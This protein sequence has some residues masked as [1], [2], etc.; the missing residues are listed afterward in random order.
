MAHFETPPL[1]SETLAHIGSFPVRNTMIMA[2]LAMAVLFLVAYFVRR[3]RYREVPGRFQGFIEIMVEALFN[4]FDSIV[5]DRK[6][7]KRFFPIVAT[8]FIFLLTA[9]WMGILPGVGSITILGEHEGKMLNLPIFRS[10]NA[11]VNMTLAIAIISV[12]ATQV[13]G[14]WAL[15]FFSYAGKFFVAPWKDPIGSFVGILELI[16][17]CAKVISF[18]FRLFGNIFA[19]EVLLVVISFLM[20]YLAPIPFMGLELFVGFIQALVFSLLTLVFIKMGTTGHGEHHESSSHAHASPS[21][22]LT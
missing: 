8:I 3:T 12:V 14:V 10:M 7:T 16:A 4:F 18:T 11:D 15:G 19:G 9:N 21:P 1:A 13:Y 20:P 22:A 2:W 6:Q 5:Q 17:E